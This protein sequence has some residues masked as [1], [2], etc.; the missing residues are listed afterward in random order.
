MLLLEKLFNA[1]SV[2]IAGAA[3]PLFSAKKVFNG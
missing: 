3:F 2:Q 1:A